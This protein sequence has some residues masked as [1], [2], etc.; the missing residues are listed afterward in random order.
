VCAFNVYLHGERDLRAYVARLQHVAGAR[1]LLIAEMGADSLRNGEDAQ[2]A[3]VTRQLDGVFGEGACGA[4]V[5]S[6]TDEWWRGGQLVGDWAFG[7]VD[8]DRRPKPAHAAVRRVFQSAPFPDDQRSAWP[9]VS[10]VV[11]A[12]NAA[13]TIDECLSAIAELRYPDFEV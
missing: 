1:P 8:S 10:V 2:A 9:R 7:L 3:L 4:I 11:C 12:Y 13:D 6:W 5:F